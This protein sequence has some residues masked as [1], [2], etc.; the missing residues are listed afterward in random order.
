MDSSPNEKS[1]EITKKG[2]HEVYNIDLGD[3]IETPEACSLIILPKRSVN[4]P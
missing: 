3:V 4:K 2:K 1:S